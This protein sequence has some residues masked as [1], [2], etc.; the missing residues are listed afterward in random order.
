MCLVMIHPVGS[1][2]EDG[3]V[4]YTGSVYGKIAA[5]NKDNGSIIWSYQAVS[6]EGNPPRGFMESTVGVQRGIVVS[7]GVK[8]ILSAVTNSAVTNPPAITIQH[9][10]QSSVQPNTPIVVNSTI[11][12]TDSI[13]LSLLYYKGPSQASYTRVT[14]TKSGDLYS[15]TIPGFSDTSGNVSYYIVSV[16]SY[17]YKFS[18]TYQVPIIPPGG[19]TTP[20]PIPT[21]LSPANGSQV[22]TLRPTLDWSDVTDPS[23][24]TYTLQVSTISTFSVL[25]VSQSGLSVSQYTFSFDLQNN[26]VYY[27]RV[28]AVD[29]AGNQSGWSSSWSFTPYIEQQDT[30]PPS[31]P[32]LLT[33]QD[34][35]LVTTLRPI[36]DWSDVT[37]PSGVS[38][39]LQ[40]ALDTNFNS[41]VINF[42]GIA[43]SQYTFSSDL[44]LGVTYYWRVKSVDGVGNQSSWSNIWS[45]I[46]IT[47]DTT[48]PSVPTLISPQNNVVL[49]TRVVH[50]DWSDVTDPSGVVY[51]LQVDDN[52]N[53]SSPIISNAFD[54]SEYTSTELVPNITHYWRV[55]AVD[56]VDNTSSWSSV[57]QFIIL[58][59]GDTTPPAKIN[60]LVA[61]TGSYEG[62]VKLSWQVTGDDG[63]SGNIINGEYRIDYSTVKNRVWKLSNYK[64]KFSTTVS[65]GANVTY[66]VDGL[67]PGCSYYFAL[68]LA[69]DAYN[70]SEMSN[71]ATGYARPK[72]LPPT[73]V[74]PLNNVVFVTTNNVKFVWENVSTAVKY[75]LQVS[76]NP[77]FTYTLIDKEVGQTSYQSSFVNGT[78]FWRVRCIDEYNNTSDWTNILTF[79]INISTE[80]TV[81]SGGYHVVEQQVL[82][83]V[84]NFL[85]SNSF[86]I[87]NIMTL[88]TDISTL[89][90]SSVKIVYRIGYTDGTFSNWK[91][92]DMSRISID[93]FLTTLGLEVPYN[94]KCIEYYYAI[95]LNNGDVIQ[96]EQKIVNFEF[97]KSQYISS[98]GGKIK[99]SD[100]NIT[101][102]ETYLDIPKGVLS[103]SKNITL[104]QYFD[105]TNLPENN[106]PG[107]KH[108][109]PISAVKVEGLPQNIA[110][111]KIIS[112]VLYSEQNLSTSSLE[113]N[114]RLFYYDGKQWHYVKSSVNTSVNTVTG[115]I[116][117][118]GIYGVFAVETVSGEYCKPQ[119]RIVF[120]SSDSDVSTKKVVFPSINMHY[121]YEIQIYDVKGRLV[122]KVNDKDFW[123]LKDNDGKTV[124]S[125]V[126]IYKYIVDNES[127]QGTILILR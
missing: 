2:I 40:V 18:S 64:I 107:V 67:L 25:I 98:S 124:P 112:S 97:K 44:D 109:H 13:L 96:T 119:Q 90:I 117:S 66:V 88:E 49:S 12:C 71:I 68:W 4:L 76:N 123:D 89:T 65:S 121:N 80:P 30:E 102:G 81:S 59:V 22:S 125:G 24:V 15:A 34:G 87:N 113:K 85:P 58:F 126:Y 17:T 104:S 116:S 50:F 55:R 21:L 100:P 36:L 37:D 41:I 31:I 78:Y 63:Y 79:G 5:V 52:Y 46:P 60:N 74:S 28:K 69:D 14:M 42:S 43:N 27:W 84:I 101:D 16:T 75:Q 118:D 54:S 11:T 3:G 56:G 103:T 127:Y 70:W 7:C 82:P 114:L 23:G 32:I 99:L 33:P 8:G 93:E 77:E 73:Q 1:I 62:S 48:P 47:I 122:K 10:P 9:T 39:A 38:Y 105:I 6:G 111:G 53:F 120:L 115:Y 91:E 26:V 35:S 86:N 95:T 72:L 29:G 51:E 108:K 106:L 45:F 94:V 57:Y 61:T 19:D 20:P 92:E 83:E 110:E